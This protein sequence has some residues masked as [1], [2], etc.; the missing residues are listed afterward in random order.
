MNS[1][2]ANPRPNRFALVRQAAKLFR[3]TTDGRSSE[4][5]SEYIKQCKDICSA[6]IIPLPKKIYGY[7]DP[8]DLVP[9]CIHTDDVG[10]T[11]GVFKAGGMIDGINIVSWVPQDSIERET[12][13]LRKRILFHKKCEAIRA[14]NNGELPYYDIEGAIIAAS[15]PYVGKELQQ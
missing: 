3:A 11:V 12:R 8:S 4:S 6:N 15:D 5:F 14:A 10:Q 13:E 9:D 7:Y 1:S 2:E